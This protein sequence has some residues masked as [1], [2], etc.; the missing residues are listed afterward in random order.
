MTLGTH[1]VIGEGVAAPRWVPDRGPERR[2][3]GC[4]VEVG[5]GGCGGC[6]APLGSG[7]GSVKT[8]GGGCPVEVGDGGCGGCRTPLGSG[9]GSGKTGEGVAVWPRNARE[10]LRFAQ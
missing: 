3:G 4:P 10:I 2:L 9:S 8:V 1:R 5:D 6:R 7:S